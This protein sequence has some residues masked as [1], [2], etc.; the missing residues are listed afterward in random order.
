MS[1]E[2]LRLTKNPD[3]VVTYMWPVAFC[4]RMFDMMPKPLCYHRSWTCLGHAAEHNAWC[5]CFTSLIAWLF[6]VL[7]Q[8][9]LPVVAHASTA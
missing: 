4:G 3:A 8:G 5:L 9:H 2:L 1:P 7:F 6:R